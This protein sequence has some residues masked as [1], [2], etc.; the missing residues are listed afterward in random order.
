MLLPGPDDVLP[1]RRNLQILALFLV[2]ADIAEQT[3]L[4]TVHIYRP[5]LLLRHLRETLRICRG[6]F[7][8]DLAAARVHDR[9]A[10]RR[11]PH[12]RDLLPIVA[13]VM[14]DLAWH[15]IRRVCHPNVALAFV[16]E[17]PGHARCMRRA[18]QT[19]GK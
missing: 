1:V 12:A 11:E 2:A 15:E 4:A 9:F 16:V 6:P 19:V 3:W 14:R 13:F 17:D 5:C 18:R 7:L 10:I 8:V